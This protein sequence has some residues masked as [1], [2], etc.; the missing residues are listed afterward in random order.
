MPVDCSRFSII[1]ELTSDPAGLKYSLPLA[2]FFFC[3]L[4]WRFSLEKAKVIC[5]FLQDL[6][7]LLPSP[8]LTHGCWDQEV[9]KGFAA[10]THRAESP[11]QSCVFYSGKC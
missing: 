1:K 3:L 11:L 4:V 5:L 7:R 2:I 10:A 6:F 8:G 9:T